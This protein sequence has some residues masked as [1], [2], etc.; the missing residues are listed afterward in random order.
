[1]PAI[2]VIVPIYNVEN[3][4]TKCVD[5]ILNQTFRDIEIILVDD[6]ST[7]NSGKICDEYLTKDDR[8]KVIHKK[9]GGLSDARNAGL[10]ICTGE[11]IGFVDGDDYIDEDMYELL[12]KNIINYDADISMCRFRR[13]YNNRID[14]NG[15]NLI[16]CTQDKKEIIEE[17]YCGSIGISVCSKLYKKNIFSNLR[18]FYGKTYEDVYITLHTVE[19]ATKVVFDYKS[20]YNYLLRT[21]SITEKKEYN[22]KIKE[23]INA[24]L[25]NHSIICDKYPELIEVSEY[26]LWWVYRMTIERIMKCKDHKEHKAEVNAFINILRY[27]IFHILGNK[28]LSIKQRMAYILICI[29]VNAY[30]KIKNTIIG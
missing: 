11:Y 9:N 18:F 16:R 1:M 8:V 3:Y 2:S 12:Y 21:N 30:L 22:K 14:D 5:S 7:D 20:K 4:V 19:K 23:E 25:Y 29:D 27:K 6:G 15:R 17:L 13:I 10:D 26:R 28:K 24:Y